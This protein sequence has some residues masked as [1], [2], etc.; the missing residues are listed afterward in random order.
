MAERI[1]YLH[2]VPHSGARWQPFIERTGGLAPDLPG[3]GSADK[4]AW[5]WFEKPD[6]IGRVAAFLDG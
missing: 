5:P 3:F 4:P 6:V 1:V 2:G